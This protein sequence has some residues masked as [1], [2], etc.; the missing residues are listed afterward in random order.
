MSDANISAPSLA[1]VTP[2]M[3]QYYQNPHVMT[4]AI[5]QCNVNKEDVQTTILQ[6]RNL[7]VRLKN[8]DKTVL[9]GKLFA[10]IDEDGCSTLILPDKVLLRLPKIEPQ[11]WLALFGRN[12]DVTA[13]LP[14]ELDCPCC[15]VEKLTFSGI[16]SEVSVAPAFLGGK[17][18]TIT[19]PTVYK[20][21]T[22]KLRPAPADLP[23][24]HS[25]DATFA[26]AEVEAEFLKIYSGDCHLEYSIK[27]VCD[28]FFASGVMLITAISSSQGPLVRLV[29]PAQFMPITLS[30]QPV[31]TQ[32][33]QAFYSALT[34]GQRT[35]ICER[36]LHLCLRT[37][38]A[39]L[40]EKTSVFIYFH[41]LTQYA[42]KKYWKENLDLCTTIA[43]LGLSGAPVGSTFTL[44]HRLVKVGEA[45]ENIGKFQN[46]GR[47][48][49]EIAN[50]F[51]DSFY[52]SAKLLKF[53]AIAYNRACDF[54]AAERIFVLALHHELA[55][56]G[57]SWASND[58]KTMRLFEAFAGL[59]FDEQ[60][61]EAQKKQYV[62]EVNA[63]ME[64][65]IGAL[66][67]ATGIH[68]ESYQGQEYRDTSFILKPKFRQPKNARNVLS[69]AVADPISISKFRATILACVKEPVYRSIHPKMREL[70]TRRAAKALARGLGDTYQD[71]YFD[72]N[73]LI[74]C[75]NPVCHEL[76]KRGTKFQCCPC[77]TVSYVSMQG[78][79]GDES[80]LM[81]AVKNHV[82]R[83]HL[84][85]SIV[86]ES[87]SGCSLES[88]AQGGVPKS[89]EVAVGLRV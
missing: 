46:A 66:C 56:T 59:Y 70:R 41:L 43:D 40:D 74:K 53:A 28:P 2:P 3:Y 76:E 77:Q 17:T 19:I 39:S 6:S 37:C 29:F 83:S 82:S 80:L 36:I 35:A 25:R 14:A 31:E 8:I 27:P 65:A 32:T 89:Q 52:D 12:E 44:T 57:G 73:Y 38:G 22:R 64:V 45:L 84:T 68:F 42:R 18:P 5:L 51:A 69:A 88:G 21:L 78:R 54:D 75:S 11:T 86:P 7:S 24:V 60:V 67:F 9:E 48:Y 49:E 1:A 30:T 26:S 13:P 34:L 20:Q 33:S 58:E 71:A 16:R 87:L 50:L 47:L 4:I 72:P 10:E 55:R 81:V 61:D 63:T 62:S 85:L 23:A 79:S 15:G